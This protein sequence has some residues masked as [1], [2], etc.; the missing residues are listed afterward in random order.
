MLWNQG[1]T[2][3][4]CPKKNKIIFQQHCQY[5][6]YALREMLIGDWGALIEIHITPILQ[7]SLLNELNMNQRLE[8]GIAWFSYP[9]SLT[10]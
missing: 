4:S 9:V 6:D 10:L 3:C 1:L 8:V 7:H 2:L 5:D